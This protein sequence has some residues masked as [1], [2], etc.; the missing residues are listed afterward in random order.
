MLIAYSEHGLSTLDS[1]I[2]MYHVKQFSKSP[3]PGCGMNT[4]L[5]FYEPLVKDLWLS[6][7]KKD[8]S[9]YILDD[10]YTYSL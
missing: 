4:T 7:E 10:L 8:M 1:F 5:L 9:T 3:I 2:I 6:T